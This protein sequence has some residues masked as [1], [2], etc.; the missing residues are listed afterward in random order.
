[1]LQGILLQNIP[2]LPLHL[3]VQDIKGLLRMS[4][5][6]RLVGFKKL[7]V[8]FSVPLENR[9]KRSDGFICSVLFP[10]TSGK[11]EGYQRVNLLLPRG[12]RSCWISTC[13]SLPNITKPALQV[14]MNRGGYRPVSPPSGREGLLYKMSCLV[15]CHPATPTADDVEKS[16]SVLQTLSTLSTK[17]PTLQECSQ[18]CP[19]KQAELICII[20]FYFQ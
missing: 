10:T 15:S 7:V 1:M 6:I 5:T 3:W 13:C 20:K 8:W 2:E 18:H 9:N 4:N 17:H 19:L 11:Q 12:K 16:V 14:L